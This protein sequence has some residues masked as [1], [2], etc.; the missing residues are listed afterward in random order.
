MNPAKSVSFMLTPA[1]EGV[2]T[3]ALAD[4]PFG[5]NWLRRICLHSNTASPLH[6]MMIEAK[7]VMAFPAHSHPNDE[8]IMVKKGAMMVSYVSNKADKG[9]ELNAGAILLIPA[10][11]VH[12]VNFL[13]PGT[14]FYEVKAGPFDENSTIFASDNE[15]Q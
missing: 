2:I 7:D 6:V 10:N 11:T 1:T 14:V 5:L 8:L 15:I 3:Q 4:M 12:L 9:I 13:A